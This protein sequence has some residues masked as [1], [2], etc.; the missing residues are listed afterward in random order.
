MA[1]TV[2]N[3]RASIRIAHHGAEAQPIIIIDDVLAA[4]EG[5]R[6][7]AARV[8]YERIGPY[9]PGVRAA[10]PREAAAAMRAELTGPIG[11]AFDLEPVPPV[12]ECF[13]SILTTPPEALAPIQRLPHVDGLE[14][15]RI[16]I[17]IYLSGAGQ[18]GTAFYRQRA[19]GS[20][21]VDE[22]RF[23]AFQAALST[24]AAEHGL[25][26]AAYIAGD[27]ALYEQVACYEA[28]PNRALVY[29]SH[30]LHC[31]AIAPGTPLPADP[32]HGRLTI[33]SFLFDPASKG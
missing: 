26:P 1:A 6:D 25:P 4:V 15:D 12:L 23:P 3:P 2:L 30:A 31:A 8:R 27:T 10:V 11:A 14:R 18:G 22:A 29:R 9:Y 7:L 33:N 17:L 13:F 21:T 24:G 28:R 5:W 32:A 20:E 19:T 16:A